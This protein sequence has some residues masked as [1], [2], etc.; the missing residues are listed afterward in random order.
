MKKNFNVN[1]AI[2]ATG[3]LTFSGV[4]IETAMNVTFPVLIKQFNV[5]TV[6]V[7]WVTTIYLLMIAVIVPL[8][9]YL[10]KNFS[11]RNLF[12]AAVLLFLT[13]V[14]VN[15]F[16]NF[17]ILLFG[18]MLQGA[19][20]GIALP[21]MFNIILTKVPVEKRGMMIGIGTMTT[22]IAP[23]IGPAYGGILTSTAG[24]PF[25]YILLLPVLLCTAAIG[26]FAIPQ[27]EIKKSSSLNFPAATALAVGFSSFLLGFSYF[28]KPFFW[29][30][31]LTGVSA[32]GI[33]YKVNQKNPLADLTV[34]KNPLFSRFLFG[35]L[36]F[37]FLL[38]GISFIIPNLM[39]IAFNVPAS[40]AGIMMFP[41]A[42][43]GAVFAPLSGRLLDRL[44]AQKPIIGG[45]IL[46]LT[47]WSFLVFILPN[48]SVW[49]TVLGHILFMI[50]VGLSYSNLMTAG[51]SSLNPQEQKEG[52]A[53][54]S[55]LQ[56]FSG[57]VATAFSALVINLTQKSAEN[58][59]DGTISGA[60]I[61]LILLLS[62]LAVS[63]V[64]VIKNLREGRVKA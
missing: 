52:N 5:D 50:D 32:S 19:A 16:P 6:Q 55:T 24:W 2:A 10:I 8:S 37:Q 61:D 28:G 30:I 58:L 9:S 59:I 38:L 40:Q 20:T 45:L 35:F 17:G 60:R 51:L 43:I 41:G 12:T 34:L 14:C 27:E 36:V 46:S 13:G 29:I 44:G 33:F 15:S 23:A 4:L 18:R 39:Q 21:L 25:I 63:C 48:G 11:I 64:I 62:L 56:Q 1:L 31:L 53:V 22:S 7:Q 49:F 42:L 26:L 47:G 57:A 54:F 3:V